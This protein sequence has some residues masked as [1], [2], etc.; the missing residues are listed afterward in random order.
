[1][2]T[3][4]KNPMI[5]A[6]LA[7]A[8]SLKS[9]RLASTISASN[10]CAAGG[11]YTVSGSDTST[12]T[13]SEH[14]INVV[15]YSC[16]DSATYPYVVLSGSLSAYDKHTFDGLS[17]TANVTAT[18]LSLATHMSSTVSSTVVLTGIFN[19]SFAIS[20]GV[21]SGTSG[22]HGSIQETSILDS[23]VIDVTVG[24]NNISDVWSSVTTTTGG[25]VTTEEHTLNGSLTFGISSGGNSFTFALSLSQL[26]DKVR[27][28]ADLSE[29]QWTNGSIS[30]NWSP[31]PEPAL[32]C[33]AR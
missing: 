31:N 22:I 9:V 7:K 6:A 16:Q 33:P 21:T 24:F 4:L 2:M 14:A 12:G 18:A 29:D 30:M 32:V 20:G 23:T 25:T 13:Y 19:K 28:N 5:G 1:M 10:P 15:Y 17:D 26:D 27:T 11:Y 3:D 8:R